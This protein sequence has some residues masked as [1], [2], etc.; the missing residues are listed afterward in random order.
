MQARAAGTGGLNMQSP[1][2]D[3]C[4]EGRS[5]LLSGPTFLL[6][7]DNTRHSSSAPPLPTSVVQPKHSAEYSGHRGSKRQADPERR[8]GHQHLQCMSLGVGSLLSPV[9]PGLRASQRRPSPLM[10]SPPRNHGLKNTRICNHINDEATERLESSSF[11][12]EIVSI[13]K[14]VLV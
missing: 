7:L 10:S 2:F 13:A 3:V 6:A 5:R 11:A 9:W 14:L 4:S 8:S 1:A 12:L